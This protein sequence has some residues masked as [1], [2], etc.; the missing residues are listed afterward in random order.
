MCASARRTPRGRRTRA[1]KVVTCREH[2]EKEPPEARN[3]RGPKAT[4]VSHRARYGTPPRAV[5]PTTGFLSLFLGDELDLPGH[6][7]EPRGIG[8][9]ADP[10]AVRD[11]HRPVGIELE[12]RGEVLVEIAAARAR[13]AGE[14][15]VRHRGEGEVRRASYPRLEHPP[16]PH[17]HAGR[18]RDIVDAA[19][20]EHPPDAALL[21][22]H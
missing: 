12:R 8:I 21:D 2:P 15:E 22:V 19:C 13:V 14:A 16:A 7:L 9:H 17:R 11:A 18:G 5:N 3:R 1:P 6:G 4:A 10:R 20:L